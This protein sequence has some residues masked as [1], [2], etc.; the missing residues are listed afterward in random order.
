[1]NM[2]RTCGLAAAILTGCGARE[3]APQTLVR[4]ATFNA[5]NLFDDVADGDEEVEDSASYTRHLAAVSAVL[6]ELGADLVILEEVENLRV[7]DALATRVTQ[8]YAQR[9]LLPGNDPRGIHVAALARVPLGRVV[10]HRDD[11][12]PS[13]SSDA[14]YRYSRDCLEIHV[15]LGGRP[16]VFFGV[17]FKSKAFP[18]DPD[19]RLAEAV[20]TRALASAVQKEDSPAGVMVLGDF[21]DVPGSPAVEAVIAPPSDARYTD[22]AA[23]AAP[24]VWSHS[25]GGTNELLDH[26]IANDVATAAAVTRGETIL[27]DEA[28]TE[29]SDHAPVAA[30]FRV[31]SSAEG[32]N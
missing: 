11:P 15:E 6:D 26:I 24:P 10:S 32:A 25:Y 8:P 23:L 7:L 27:H 18:D 14:S 2:T 29:A 19:K 22:L 12:L 20:H 21:N 3:P 1:M 28:V 4:V 16:F 31:T 9:V 13:P 17:H 5:H 30:T